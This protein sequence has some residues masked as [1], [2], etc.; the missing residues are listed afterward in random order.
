M[1]GFWVVGGG[2]SE[3]L[4]LGVTGAKTWTTRGIGEAEV[5]RV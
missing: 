1:E 4:L 5:V 3:G 2:L